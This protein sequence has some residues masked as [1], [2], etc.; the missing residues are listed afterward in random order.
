MIESVDRESVD[1]GHTPVPPAPVPPGAALWTDLRRTPRHVAEAPGVT[2]GEHHRHP[3]GLPREEQPP[4]PQRERGSPLL[5]Q[6]ATEND[7]GT[8]AK[9]LRWPERAG[10]RWP[11]GA[12]CPFSVTTCGATNDRA[13]RGAH[14]SGSRRGVPSLKANGRPM[15][16]C[17]CLVCSIPS[18]ASIVACKSGTVTGCES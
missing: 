7:F 3:T 8:G 15:G 9:R 16:V 11:P 13:E 5:A 4:S 12:E 2:P 10:V 18:A 17:N 1:R 6:R 14:R